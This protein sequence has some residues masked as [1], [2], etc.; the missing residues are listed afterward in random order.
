MPIGNFNDVEPLLPD[1]WGKDNQASAHNNLDHSPAYLYQ[2]QRLPHRQNSDSAIP[3]QFYSDS[4]LARRNSMPESFMHESSVPAAHPPGL[5]GAC[6][7]SDYVNSMFGP[8][9]G[10]DQNLLSG[11]QGLSLN[12]DALGWR[13]SI[14]GWGNDSGKKDQAQRSEQSGAL[15]TRLLDSSQQQQQ[16]QQ[17]RFAWG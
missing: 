15:P 11:I 16:Q 1:L 6:K 8:E 7:E 3:P 10:G 17:S 14:A 2:G 5:A 9:G 12:N 13:S 4:R